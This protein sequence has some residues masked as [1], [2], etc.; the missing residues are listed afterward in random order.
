MCLL[1]L[2]LVTK[3]LIEHVSAFLGKFQ[4]LVGQHMGQRQDELT[5]VTDDLAKIVFVLVGH[6]LDNRSENEAENGINHGHIG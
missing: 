2:D 5:V 3:R 1:L 6:H 4:V